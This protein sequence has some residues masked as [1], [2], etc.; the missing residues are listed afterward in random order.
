MASGFDRCNPPLSSNM[1]K[2]TSQTH[3]HDMWLNF[4]HKWRFGQFREFFCTVALWKIS[5]FP[6]MC[7]I[8]STHGSRDMVAPIAHGLPYQII[9]SKWRSHF[10]AR[11]I[12]LIGA[13]HH[14]M[15]D[16][17]WWWVITWFALSTRELFYLV[18]EQAN[19]ESAHNLITVSINRVR[20][21]WA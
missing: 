2:R 4:T 20:M 21:E 19:M 5:N 17:Y 13:Q 6:Q 12:F 15:F 3:C 16:N 10:E 18:W 9:Y 11:I 8:P 7:L 14:T 1:D